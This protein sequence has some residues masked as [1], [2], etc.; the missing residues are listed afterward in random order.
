MSSALSRTN[1][2]L[3]S[4]NNYILM[5]LHTEFIVTCK[6][7]GT[8][9]LCGSYYQISL[10]FNICWTKFLPQGKYIC[11]SI[12]LKTGPSSQRS[13]KW[14]T[15]GMG[16]IKRWIKFFI[17][18]NKYAIEAQ[19]RV[20]KILK[21]RSETKVEKWVK[22]KNKAVSTGKENDMNKDKYEN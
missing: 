14:H 12:F 4:S 1:I 16:Q 20:D 2:L 22:K 6:K 11:I 3:M 15:I 13:Y 18:L 5:L 9:Y 19:Y 8:I 21:G 17:I 10:I 7:I